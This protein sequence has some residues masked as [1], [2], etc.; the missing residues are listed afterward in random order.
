MTF[1]FNYNMLCCVFFFCSLSATN[2]DIQPELFQIAVRSLYTLHLYSLPLSLSFSPISFS[3]VVRIIKKYQITN[4][5]ETNRRTYRITLLRFLLLSSCLHIDIY[6]VFL[7]SFVISL[8]LSLSVYHL[9]SIYLSYPRSSLILQP[10]VTTN[11]TS[12]AIPL[13]SFI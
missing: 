5:M 8:F 12:N 3:L 13:L 6:L 1:N 7:R 4:R 2:I 9:P 10:R 11:Y